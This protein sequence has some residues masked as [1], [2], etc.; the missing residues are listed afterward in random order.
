M[1]TLIARAVR[2]RP[3]LASAE[4]QV[5]E[6]RARVRQ[7][8]A[9]RLPSLAL[10]GSGGRTYIASPYAAGNNYTVQ[11]GLSIPLFSGFTR[12]YNQKQAE[13]LADAA[14]ASAAGLKQ[15]VVYQ[16]FSSYYTLQT[17]ARRVATADDLLTSAQSSADAALARYRAGVGGIVDLLTAQSALAAARAQQVQAQWVWQSSL[18]QLA[19]DAGALDARGGMSIHLA[20]AD[21]GQVPPR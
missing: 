1:D 21:S 16:V 7:V 11:L 5:A 14:A 18:A 4:A 20:P 9:A 2:D 12:E 19:H 10:S 15:Q 8:R 17:A 13:A 3:D 6:A